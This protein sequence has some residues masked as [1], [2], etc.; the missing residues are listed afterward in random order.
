MNVLAV[1]TSTNALQI[2]LLFCSRFFECSC[3]FG[4]HHTEHLAVET[5]EL[6]RKAGIAAEELELIA[7]T[8]G[9]GSFT[10][11]RIGMSFAKGYAAGLSLPLVSLPTLDLLAY[12]KEYFK[13]SVFPVIDARK[14]RIY[15]ARYIGGRRVGEFLDIHPQS[16]VS[17]LS[18]GEQALI[19]GPYAFELFAKVEE[20]LASISPPPQIDPLSLQPRGR[21]LVDMATTYYRLHGPDDKSAGP[22]YVR[23]SEAEL[24]ASKSTSGGKS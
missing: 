20:G 15:T 11:L 14:N 22:L 5:V 9:P 17:Y 12:G 18:E 3:D 16:I 21:A 19:T 4:L 23:P 8:S 6:L 7:C 2:S 13:G 24:S 1:D 10:G